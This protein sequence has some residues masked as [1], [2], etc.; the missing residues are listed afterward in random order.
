MREKLIG[1]PQ[2]VLVAD[3][4]LEIKLTVTVDE[5]CTMLQG[6]RTSLSSGLLLLFRILEDLD[7]ISARRGAVLIFD[8][9]SVHSA[10]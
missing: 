5:R 7:S 9:F 10:K 2:N 1:R 3:W 6:K 4:I 8:F